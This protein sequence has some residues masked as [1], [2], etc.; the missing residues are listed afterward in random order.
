MADKELGSS[1][2]AAPGADAAEPKRQAEQALRPDASSE[3]MHLMTFSTGV[4][5]QHVDNLWW[6][7]G[8]L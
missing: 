5:R 2:A 3:T 1:G 7:S 6:A 8:E 4:H